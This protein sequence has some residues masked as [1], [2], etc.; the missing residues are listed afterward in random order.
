MLNM[1]NIWLI[2]I[3]GMLLLH[4]MIPHR[5]HEEMTFSEHERSHEHAKNI[6]DYLELAFHQ[7]TDY[8]LD[9]IISEQCLQAENFNPSSGDSLHKFDFTELK[10]LFN[11]TKAK[12]KLLSQGYSPTFI[13]CINGL[14]APPIHGYHL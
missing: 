8:S 12:Y 10:F 4:V 13:T 5:H 7:A 1:R 6:I 2:Q 9:N 3:V 14:R 11:P